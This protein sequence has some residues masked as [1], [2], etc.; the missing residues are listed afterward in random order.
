MNGV[1]SSGIPDFLAPHVTANGFRVLAF[2][3]EHGPLVARAAA[4]AALPALVGSGGMDHLA[5][6]PEAAVR[7]FRDRVEPTVDTAGIS[8][9]FID[10]ADVRA[11]AAEARNVLPKPGGVAGWREYAGSTMSVLTRSKREAAQIV[12]DVLGT[13]STD[14]ERAR[15]LRTTLFAYLRHDR[16]WQSTAETLSIHRQTLG[17]RLR[18]IEDETNLHVSR[19]ADL[20]AAW[21]AYQAWQTLHNE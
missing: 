19:S 4:A 9:V 21:I 2:D 7:D 1:S 8:S 17:Y 10:L 13:L 16:N 14:D 20:A 5:L 11:A 12:A 3:A 15:T 6:V 18:R